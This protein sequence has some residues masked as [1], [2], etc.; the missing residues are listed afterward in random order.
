MSFVY[1]TIVNQME[2]FLGF[3]C[4]F[5]HKF[6]ATAV[7]KWNCQHSNGSSPN[8]TFSQLRLEKSTVRDSMQSM[9]TAE[10]FKYK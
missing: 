6:P 3:A 1:S 9:Q 5:K 7:C 4:A 8:K 2:K 10:S